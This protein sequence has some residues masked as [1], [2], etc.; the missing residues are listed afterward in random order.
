MYLVIYAVVEVENGDN[1][2]WFLGLLKDDL[3]RHNT[4]H[5]T[6]IL[7]KQNGLTNAIESLFEN[8]EHRTCVRHLYNN[9]S[10]SH[11]DLTLKNC[12]R[13]VVRATTVSQW[14]EHMQRMLDLDPAAYGWLEGKPASHWSK[15]HFRKWNQCDMLLNN[16]CESFNSTIVTA[17]EKPTLTMLEDIRVYLIR[18]IVG[19]RE[20]CDRW[21]AAIGPRI[22]KILEKN[23]IACSHVIA[24]VVSRGLNMMEFVDDIYKKVAYMRTYTPSISPITGPSA[25]PTPCLNPLNPPVYTKRAGK[26]KKN[27]RKEPNEVASSMRS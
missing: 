10:L 4:Q 27:R 9:F 25:W 14:L 11:K 1:Q 2:R 21:I 20:S 7:D 3:H 23:G 6:F 19:R 8:S 5:W 18:R 13:D 17:R 12:L 16:L 24:F 15:S 22:L 26:P